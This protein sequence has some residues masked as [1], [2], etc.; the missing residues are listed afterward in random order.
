MKKSL[1]LLCLT[2]F[3][4]SLTSFSQDSAPEVKATRENQ[5]ATGYY[6]RVGP[7]IPVGNFRSLQ[8]ITEPTTNNNYYY[9]RAL[10]GGVMEMGYL[11][12]LGPS[13]ANKY[14]RAG[15][16]AS[17]LSFWFN[18]NKTD[19]VRSGNK[20][21]YWYY[22]V[23]QK[24][25]PIISVNPVDKLIIDVSYKINAVL[26]FNRHI[27][28]DKYFD[29]WGKNLFQNEINLNIEYRLMMF[30]FEYNFGKVTFDNL[31]SSNPPHNV[32][33]S[34]FRVLFGFKL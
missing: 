26:A 9:E 3:I 23:G 12:Y 19:S 7:V 2:L 4:S 14:L 13:F 21:Q 15:I 18:P 6:F 25:G 8:V 24:F 27:G 5:I 32:D 20:M 10:T 30:S 33:V 31:D 29:E 22:F 1:P 16:D 17:F 34:T 28:N 11:I